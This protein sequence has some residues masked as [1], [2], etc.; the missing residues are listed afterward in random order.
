MSTARSS[1]GGCGLQTATLGFGGYIN[2]PTPNTALTEEYDGTS[3][4][5]GG[6]L[7][8]ARKQAAGAGT[9][10]LGL[11]FGGTDA[12]SGGVLASTEEYNGTSWSNTSSMSSA[13][14]QLEGDG[15]RAAAL[16]F[17]GTS[18]GTA[19][20]DATEEFTQSATNLTV[21]ET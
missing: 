8:T 5:A 15:T 16:A 17:M 4:T 21:T 13:R 20:F 11:A 10:T 9:Q 18:P 7:N 3:W 6:S 14:G 2:S 12:P 1:I 19:Y